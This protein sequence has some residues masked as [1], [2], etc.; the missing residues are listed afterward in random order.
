MERKEGMKPMVEVETSV[1]G[2][3]QEMMKVT[4]KKVVK[5]EHYGEKNAW[6][7]QNRREME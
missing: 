3:Q 4:R 1:N 6:M 5:K 7:V 2:R